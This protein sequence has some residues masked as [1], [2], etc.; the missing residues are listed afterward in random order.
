MACNYL[1]EG[2]EGGWA[3][4]NGFFGESAHFVSENCAPYEA[5][6]KGNE[7]SK[8]KKCKPLAKIEKSYYLANYNY[9]PTVSM[10]QKEM[11]LNGP[12]VTEFKC[13]DMFGLYKEGILQQTGK[14]VISLSEEQ[15]LGE[16]QFYAQTKAQHSLAEK[17]VSEPTM[18]M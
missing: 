12:V 9:K 13:D 16:V 14:K 6:T 7:C 15:Q 3:I 8:Y 5:S 18:H 10:I 1:N 17:K 2:C 11:L 4:L